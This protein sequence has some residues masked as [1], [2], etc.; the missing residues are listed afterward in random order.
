MREESWREVKRS[1]S[2]P[3]GGW[4]LVVVA[5]LV[6]VLAGLVAAGFESLVHLSESFFFSRIARHEFDGWKILL[7][8]PLPA[9]GGLGVGLIT[10]YIS[11]GPPGHGI[12]DVMEALARRDG[13]LHSKTGLLKMVTASLTIGS[14]GSAG[15]EGPIVQIG[16]VVGSAVARHLHVNREHRNTLVGCGAAAGLAAIFNAPIA[17]VIFVLEVILRDFSLRTFMPVVV[18]SVLGVATIRAIRPD[19]P[20]FSVPAVLTRDYPFT[21]AKMPPFIVL[22][23]L[24]GLVG[25]LFT[26]S[27]HAQEGYWRKLK[28]HPVVRPALGG[29]ALGVL[30]V[31]F[32][33]GFGR[34]VGGYEPPVFFSNG[35]PVIQWLFDPSTYLSAAPVRHATFM[36]LVVAMT[37]KIVGTGFTLGSG[38]SGGTF[39][40]ALFIGA[41]LGGAMGI[42]VRQIPGLENVTPAN[43]ALVGMA[44]VL[45]GTVHC[46]MTAFLLVFELT[47]DYKLILPT[48]LVAVL[49]VSISRHLMHDSI[50]TRTLREM[51]VR[52][53]TLSD[54]T[55]L[56]RLTATESMLTPAIAVH[57]RDPVQKLIELSLSNG[58]AHFVVVDED[59]RY[60]GMVLDEDLRMAL[61]QR[62]SI[63]L[64]VV[65]DLRRPDLPALH[66]G[67]N[68][69]MV[70]DKFN[71]E[72]VA[73]LP[74]VRAD[75]RVLGIISRGSVMQR[76]LTALEE[77]T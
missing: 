2:G 30:G 6:G 51:G 12:P 24:C 22:G 4:L 71:H 43:F 77:E 26:W 42:V 1:L 40:P 68:L 33:L 14:G 35:Y 8:I 11:K 66:L 65:D 5:G 44:G 28:L 63:P 70:L 64:L 47:N 21:M 61:L 49:A 62:E 48:M 38:G 25:V 73:Y 17:G 55:I 9:L 52:I 23:I 41:T 15:V 13:T 39:A 19:A 60:A 31:V 18:A 72:S 36:L 56:R 3:A 20:L 57:P 50:Y 69:E 16:S 54:L 45:A 75:N 67:E 29:L 74:V 58:A 27:F 53:G 37:L 59:Q 34:G 46:P 32:V 76:Y 10:H 7:L